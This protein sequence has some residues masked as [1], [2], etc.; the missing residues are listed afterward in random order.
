MLPYLS[1]SDVLRKGLYYIGVDHKRQAKMSE[2]RKE[3]FFHKHFGSFPPIIA[4]IWFD[5]CSTRNRKARLE[6]K[7]MTERGFIRFMLAHYF[8]WTYPKNVELMVS[9]FGFEVCERY[10]QG[11]EL[12]YW[13]KKIAAM[14]KEK[15]V[16][17]SPLNQ[18]DTAQIPISV[19]GVNFA[20]WEVKHPTLNKDSSH[21]DH[22][23]NCC[24]FKYEIGLE[25]YSSQIAWING[26]KKA[27]K[28]DKTI[29]Q[30]RNG[31]KDRLA[32][33]PGKM[34]V[35]DGGYEM[36]FLCIPNSLDSKELKNFKSRARCRHESLNGRL[37]NF[38]IL[39][40]KFRHGMKNHKIAFEAVAVIVQ[41][42]MDNGSPLFEV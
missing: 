29:F 11:G 3:E 20:A 25:I 31:L 17:R 1:P 30:E 28:N 37:C 5:L 22:K 16:W 6:K 21:F 27:G 26:P 41:Y 33:G 40:D 34:G 18:D 19:D 23:H 42:Q 4:S 7:E 2:R 14:K 15:I 38:K 36:G 10:M 39:Q 32:D 24:G 12:W 13:P 35:A 9:Q 8:L